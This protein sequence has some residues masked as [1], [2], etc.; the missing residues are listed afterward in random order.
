MAEVVAALHAIVQVKL[1]VVAQVVEAELVV[2]AVGHIGGIGFAALLIVEIM[3][4]D[5]DGQ[6]KKAV[7]LAHP[8][9]VAFGQ[10]VIDRDH[11]HTAPAQSVQ[12][13]RKRRDQGLSFAGLHFGD[14]A[15][16]QHHAADQLHIE[17]PHVQDAA[18]SLRGPRRRLLPGFR[19]ALR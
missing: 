1:H 17:V 6:T 16:V 11:V 4:D 18:A 9:R 12:I 15:L 3:H 13:D 2:G 14:L 5:A 8:L 7:E 10:I 19:R